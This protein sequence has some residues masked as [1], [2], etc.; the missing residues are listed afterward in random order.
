MANYHLEVTVIS[1]GKGRSLTRAV[2][3][4]SGKRLRDNYRNETYYRRR[5][6]V[7][8]CRIFHPANA[9]PEFHDL[10][11]LCDSIERAEKRCDA[12]TAREFKGSLPNELPLRE[13]IRIVSSFIEHNFIRQ[14]LCAVAAIHQG[15]NVEDPSRDNPHVHI[16]VPTRTVEPEGFSKK[17]DRE[18]DKR[19][20]IGIWREQWAFVQNRAYERNGLEIR[21]SHES[22]EAQGELDREPTIHLSRIDWQKERRGERTLAGDEKREIEERNRERALE[23]QRGRERSRKRSR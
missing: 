10:Q 3:Y 4:I 15:K 14:G 7:P 8:Y 12:R 19:E 2:H 20:Y 22:L 21:V 23:R 11:I 16:I 1:R 5:D 6:D 13:Q 17:K 9:P 18:H